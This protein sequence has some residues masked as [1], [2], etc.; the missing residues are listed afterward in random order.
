MHT[1]AIAI[2]L[3]SSS[4]DSTNSA[5]VTPKIMKMKKIPVCNTTFC[6]TNLLHMFD[7]AC[8]PVFP[9]LRKLLIPLWLMKTK[10]YT[11]RDFN[12]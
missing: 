5:M 7:Q 4:S 11:Q 3:Y 10:L 2:I 8:P 12:L 6:L 9:T 1:W